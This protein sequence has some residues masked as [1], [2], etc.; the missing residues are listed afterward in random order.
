MARSLATIMIRM[1]MPRFFF[2]FFDGQTWADDNVGIDLPSS[3]QAYLE[4]FAGARGMWSELIG[5]RC[6]PMACAF[7][8][9]GDD[10]QPLFRLAFSELVECCWVGGSPAPATA[11]TLE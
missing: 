8:I 7:A 10:G 9:R 5:A 3:E 2:D 11:R 4:A 1:A 6:D